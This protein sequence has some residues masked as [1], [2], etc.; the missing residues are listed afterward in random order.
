MS[1]LALNYK[2]EEINEGL[3]LKVL[4][5]IGEELGIKRWKYLNKPELLEAILKAFPSD[6]VEEEIKIE[7]IE[8]APSFMYTNR[9][10]AFIKANST[11]V[12]T[13]NGE[14]KSVF[15]KSALTDEEAFFFEYE[16]N[17]RV[18]KLF[19]KDMWK[20][21]PII[22]EFYYDSDEGEWSFRYKATSYSPMV[23]LF[24]EYKGNDIKKVDIFGVKVDLGDRY[25]YYDS[26]ISVRTPGN[27]SEMQKISSNGFY[28]EDKTIVLDP[29]AINTAEFFKAA[30]WGPS[31][32]KKG[33]K[34]FFRSKNNKDSIM[35][36]FNKLDSLTGYAFTDEYTKEVDVK[37]LMKDISRWGN[38]T[39]NMKVAYKINLSTD[40]I[41]YVNRPK[42]TIK[43]KE[44]FDKKTLEE[45]K[46]VGIDF[47]SNLT[48]GKNYLDA[49]EMAKQV[50]KELGIKFK[51][52]LKIVRRWGVQ[53]RCDFMNTKCQAEMLDTKEMKHQLKMFKKLYGSNVQVIG[54]PKGYCKMIVD[55]DGAKMISDI[56]GDETLTV[57]VM[58]I[59]GA[60]ESSTSNQMLAKCLAKDY[61]KTIE[62][63]KELLNKHLMET[64]KGNLSNSYS[65]P[66]KGA[67]NNIAALGDPK[68]G[69]FDFF[70]MKGSAINL[71]A[72]AKKIWGKDKIHMDSIYNHAMFDDAWNISG[73]RIDRVL[74]LKAVRGK[75][76]VEAFSYDVIKKY[77]KEIAEIE[78]SNMTDVEKE[79]ALDE[80]LTATVIKY[81]SA[82]VEEFLAIRYLTLTEYIAKINAALIAAS[83]TDEKEAELIRGRYLN[84]PFGE[85]LFAGYNFIKQKLAGMDID[86]D[87]IVAVLD[88]Y[89]W[90]LFESDIDV[91]T[92]IDYFEESK[93]DYSVFNESEESSLNLSDVEL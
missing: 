66:K 48:D 9:E 42:E 36:V 72:V 54:N 85:T 53:N 76:T 18:A 87:G 83:I 30:C 58:A 16:E 86:Y 68:E 55:E 79:E 4:R 47:G 22:R 15:V 33:A 28:V 37:K 41:V 2:K 49:F 43:S 52:A 74:K 13:E 40:Y 63:S 7:K 20:I 46:K 38:Y 92:F 84:L 88:K 78:N 64:F 1:N 67:L 5:P 61:D 11:I 8:A 65:H 14:E 57:W 91:I 60:S 21:I 73:G 17:R 93:A 70:L 34:Y 31:G 19:Q 59:A 56:K 26:I 23:Q 69:L 12:E 10:G 24:E 6:L 32:E 27:T 80:L 51:K 77:Y 89:K 25:R 50:S 90:I 39:T 82:G 44:D 35:R 75:S 71:S 45:L 3:T 29:D 62:L 81:P